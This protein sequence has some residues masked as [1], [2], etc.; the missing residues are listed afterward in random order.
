MAKAEAH[1]SAIILHMQDYIL[2]WQWARTGGMGELNSDAPA[3]LALVI[4]S[5]I[6]AWIAEIEVLRRDPRVRKFAELRKKIDQV[7]A[8]YRPGPSRSGG[9]G[10]GRLGIP[11]NELSAFKADD[12][13]DLVIRTPRARSG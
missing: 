7:D 5:E 10:G 8:S 9:I 2:P 13:E 11:A 3:S 1:D 6:D 12:L 4:E